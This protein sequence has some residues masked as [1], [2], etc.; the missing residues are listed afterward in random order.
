[1]G[2]QSVQLHSMASVCI[3]M[4]TNVLMG[5]PS[6]EL[7]RAHNLPGLVLTKSQVVIVWYLV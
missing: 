4:S 7:V 5:T 2:R 3:Y 6:V 1:M